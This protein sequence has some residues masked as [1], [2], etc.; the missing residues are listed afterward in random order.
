MAPA[1]AESSPAPGRRRSFLA[2]QLRE[3]KR[4]RSSRVERMPRERV[5][6]DGRKM[7]GRIADFGSCL[8]LIDDPV[9]GH[10][11]RLIEAPL[12]EAILALVQGVQDFDRGEERL[13][14]L[15]LGEA[16]F[17]ERDD[18]HI[19]L[20]EDVGS[21]RDVGRRGEY[22]A[23]RF[24]AEVPGERKEEPTDDALVPEARRTVSPVASCLPRAP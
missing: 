12:R 3:R 16:G 18:E 21:P 23:D 15:P 9:R 7:T 11:D 1:R 22:F 20:D 5:G 13:D 6:L 14:G 24:L 2:K 4:E 17:L 19:Q 10:A 8:L